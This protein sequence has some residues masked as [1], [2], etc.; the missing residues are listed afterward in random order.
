MADGKHPKLAGI[1][2]ETSYIL[3]VIY[4]DESLTLEM[5]FHL[6]EDHP[7][8]EQSETDEGCYKQ[9]FIRFADMDDLRLKKAKPAEG[10]DVDLSDIY[11]AQ[12]EGEYAFLS[13]GWGEIELTA[14][15]I[16][17]ALD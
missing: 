17:I 11:S 12:F 7:A 13:S 8:Y 9:G 16:Q 10:G 14:K 15:S 2:M 3:G 5:D 4:D 6:L 1:E